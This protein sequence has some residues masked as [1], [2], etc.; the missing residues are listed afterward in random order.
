MLLTTTHS[1]DGRR[2]QPLGLVHGT[3]VYSKNA[4]KDFGQAMKSLVGGE[5]KSYTD[6]LELATT[7]A[8][9]RM[10]DAATA[11]GAD[12]IIAVS[13][14]SCNMIAEGGAEILASGTAVKFVDI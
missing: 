8:T 2:C 3:A 6:L 11:L 7:T 12:A 1:I 14:T 4:V 5:L 9:E 10:T 13:Y